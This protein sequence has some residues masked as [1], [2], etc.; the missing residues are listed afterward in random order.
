MNVKKV[1]GMSQIEVTRKCHRFCAGNK[2]HPEFDEIDMFLN[3]T[4]LPMMLDCKVHR[5][6]IHNDDCFLFDQDI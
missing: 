6:A 5:A 3:G 1:P 4:L 2:S